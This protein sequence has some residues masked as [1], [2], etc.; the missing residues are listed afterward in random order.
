MLIGYRS[1]SMRGRDFRP[2]QNTPATQNICRYNDNRL[3]AVYSSLHGFWVSRHAALNSV[4]Q[5][6]AVARRDAYSIVLFDRSPDTCISNDLARS[7]DD[8]LSAIVSQQPGTGTNFTGALTEA[9]SIM[10]Q[11]W[12]ND[13]YA[14][15]VDRHCR[16]WLKSQRSPVLIFLSDGECSVSDA[17]VRSI[18]RAAINL[19]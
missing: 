7:P 3:G 5:N 14:I 4:G 17:T 6:A 8:L 2:L 18:C 16:P 19:G 15:S 1:S 11:H 12:S 10:T 9:Q 13:R